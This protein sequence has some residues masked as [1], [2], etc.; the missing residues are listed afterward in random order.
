MDD[1]VFRAIVPGCLV[2]GL[3]ALAAMRALVRRRAQRE[4]IRVAIVSG[5]PRASDRAASVLVMGSVVMGA[6]VVLR[7]LW[8][9]AVE[10]ALTPSLLAPATAVRWCGLGLMVSGLAVYFAGLF[11]LGASWRVGIDRDSPG[12][13]VTAGPFAVVRH[14]LYSGVLLSTGGL[15]LLTADVVV[16]AATAAVWMAVP[17]QARLEEEFLAARYPEYEAY[18]A[19][20]GRFA[21]RWR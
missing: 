15:A 17:I 7:A 14:P 13:L 10:A 5:T 1:I 9:R 6:D 21:P 20:T 18:R 16:I 4:A 8:P 2:F 3:A 12:P 19:R 11:V